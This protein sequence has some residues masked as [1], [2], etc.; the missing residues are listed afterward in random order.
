MS[1]TRGFGQDARARAAGGGAR[2]AAPWKAWGPYLSERQWGTVRED[3][4]AGRRRLELLHPR[5]GALA[6]L[7]LGRGRHRRHLRRAPAAVP[8]AGAVERRRPDPQGADV[9][10]HQQR[11]Q[12]RRG[13]QGVL[14]LP[15]QHADALV[16]EVPVQVPAAGVPVRRPGRHQRAPRQ[17]GH[18]VRAA[19]HRHLR[20]GPLLRRGRR[21]RQGRARRHPDA[22][23]PR[24]TAGPDAATLHLLPTLWFR[25]TWSWGDDGRE[26][27]ARAADGAPGRR[28]RAVAPRARRV[29][30]A[31]RG[32]ARA[33]VLRE[34]D[35]QRAA[36]RRAER[37]A[38]R[39]GR[40]S[41]TSWST[42]TPTRSTPDGRA[43]R[44][45]RTTCWTIARRRERD[46]PAA[47][48]ARATRAPA[49]TPL[50]A[51]FDACSPR[52]ATRPTSST[53]RSS[54]RRSPPT[55]RW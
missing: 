51:D 50:G 39:Q 22:A 13:R 29:A 55:R 18:G 41:T 42:A 32:R 26:A 34:R 45:P 14:V 24:T 25:N 36:V 17:A 46:D 10:P 4:S 5:S 12:P 48:D 21:V 19:R 9:R 7:P 54:R 33:A 16:P 40:R 38:V 15:R 3:Y 52:A 35:Q 37:L 11:G 20:R 53:R 28:A 47:P 49:T 1:A 27:G 43:P 8:G 44:R 23:S 2:R 6:R 30:A 31:R